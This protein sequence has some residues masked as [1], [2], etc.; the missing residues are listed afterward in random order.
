MRTLLVI[1]LAA[2]AWCAYGQSALEPAP[3]PHR[4]APNHEFRLSAGVLPLFTNDLDGWN[5][6]YDFGW[7]FESTKRYLG[8][9]YTTGALTASYSF[10]CKKWDF[11]LAVSWTHEYCRVHSNLDNSVLRRLST[12]FLSVIPTVRFSWF[13]YRSLRLYSACGMGITFLTGDRNG[14]TQGSAVGMQL[15]YI[16]IS[17]GKR[18]FGFAELGTG[19]H[20]TLLGGVGFRF[21]S[22]SGKQ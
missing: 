16:G 19:A 18:V 2:S 21:N 11:G 17:A 4:A 10:R 1:L 3:L 6:P 22:K 7:G 12:S 14:Y 5:D 15:T 9:T 8:P 20:G 13:S